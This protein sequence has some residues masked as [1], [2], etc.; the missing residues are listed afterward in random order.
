VLVSE[1]NTE[2]IPADTTRT[3]RAR[4]RRF[5]RVTVPPSERFVWGMVGLIIALVGAIVL[6]GMYL[7]LTGGKVS[8]ELLAVISGL[9]GS[10]TTSVVMGKKS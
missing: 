9:V 4:A 8:M 5:R 7:V 1:G 2:N 3:G 10:L 6:E